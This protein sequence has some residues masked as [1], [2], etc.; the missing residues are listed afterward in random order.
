MT[1][2]FYTKEMIDKCVWIV[3]L[4]LGSCSLLIGMICGAIFIALYNMLL[5]EAGIALGI[6]SAIHFTLCDILYNLGSWAKRDRQRAQVYATVF[7]IVGWC[8][9]VWS[10]FWL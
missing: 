4:V 5:I 7:R 1:Y 9:W 8:F 2:H 10:G 3:F 6:I